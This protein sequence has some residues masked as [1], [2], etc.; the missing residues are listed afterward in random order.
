[1]KSFQYFL[2]GAGLILTAG[3]AAANLAGP[4]AMAP[5]AERNFDIGLA[6]AADIVVILAMWSMVELH[7]ARN[8]ALVFV[9]TA[10]WALASVGEVSGACHWMEG[11][12]AVKV[13]DK[14]KADDAADLTKAS[15]IR[16]ERSL[17]DERVNLAG[18][19]SRML[20]EKHSEKM[21]DLRRLQ[22]ESQ[23]RIDAISKK[24]DELSPRASKVG[25]VASTNQWAGYELHST[26]ALWALSQLF[27]FVAM[28]DLRNGNGAKMM[29]AH[30]NPIDI[31]VR[32]APRRGSLSRDQEQYACAPECL[33]PPIARTDGKSDNDEPSVG[34]EQG[35]QVRIAPSDDDEKSTCAGGAH[36]EVCPSA[37]AQSAHVQEQGA[38]PA[39]VGKKSRCAPPAQK[40]RAGAQ[41]LK[42]N[43]SCKVLPMVR[44]PRDEQMRRCAEM[45]AQGMS[46]AAIARSLGV[47]RRTVQ[48]ALEDAKK[49]AEQIVRGVL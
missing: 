38:H 1:M 32:P 3:L 39:Q 26:V 43:D 31:V 44:T 21:P 46:Q 20:A 29:D 25:I 35:A 9:F 6:A 12:T 15:I 37:T 28:L 47:S 4:L 5:G 48:R 17:Q 36:Q 49:A 42:S 22:S 45:D 7:R 24:I 16:E 10:V 41:S 19:R 23:A 27:W 13:A 34:D 30:T 8:P 40:P 14:E 11:H 18:I 2:G 33:A